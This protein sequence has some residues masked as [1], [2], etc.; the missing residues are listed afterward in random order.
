[1]RKLYPTG[2]KIEFSFKG[3]K[4]LIEETKSKDNMIIMYQL[5]ISKHSIKREIFD[6]HANDT[7]SDFFYKYV[8]LSNIGEKDHQD[9]EDEYYNSQEY[10]DDMFDY[11]PDYIEADLFSVNDLIK[12]L[13][14]VQIDALYDVYLDKLKKQINTKEGE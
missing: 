6:K 4:F 1:M 3:I 7:D 14:S 9:W 11:C 13:K 5:K 10:L 8:L 12:P 2:N